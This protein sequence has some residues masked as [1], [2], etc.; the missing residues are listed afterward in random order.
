MLQEGL[1]PEDATVPD[2]QSNSNGTE[3]VLHV[4]LPLRFTQWGRDRLGWLADIYSITSNVCQG[5]RAAI[6][7]WSKE[8]KEG[9]RLALIAMASSRLFVL[10]LDN[11]EGL[12][13]PENMLGYTDRLACISFR[14]QSARPE[15]WVHEQ[16]AGFQIG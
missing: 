1:D 13:Q 6:P 3:K 4:G 2:A 7:L 11:G 9:S 10:L 8:R 14:A 16:E 12:A 15:R 5:P